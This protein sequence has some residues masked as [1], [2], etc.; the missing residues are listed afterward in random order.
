MKMMIELSREELNNLQFPVMVE[1]WDKVQGSISKKRKYKLQF[2]NQER[3]TIS[4]YYK[5]FYNWY[6]VKGTP[7]KAVMNL[8]TLLILERAIN[9][10]GCL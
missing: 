3:E 10:F 2:T 8:K 1:M 9:F 4:R 7:E 6:L 5:I